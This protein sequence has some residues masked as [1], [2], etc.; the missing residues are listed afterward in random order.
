MTMT[1]NLTIGFDVDEVCV[2][3]LGEWLRRYNEAY[4]DTQTPEDV[5]GWDMVPNV[6]AECGAKIYEF[7][8][9]PEFYRNVLPMPYARQVVDAVRQMGHRVVFV[10]SCMRG[11]MD[12]KVNCLE[13]CGFLPKTGR[14]HTDFIAASDKAL[15]TG[16]DM[17]F[18]DNTE[19]VDRYP[20]LAFLVDV[21][22]NR[23]TPCRRQRVELR[24]IPRIVSLYS[25]SPYKEAA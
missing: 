9:E 4:N 20:G 1:T 8:K 12:D 25:E 2:N 13:R 11:T 17:L 16:L 21:P 24:E 5:R 14:I 6:K 23:E 10:T 15:V 18:D 3:L 19:T 22:H 7:L